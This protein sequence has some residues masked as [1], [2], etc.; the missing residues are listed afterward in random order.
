[1]GNT[2]N[3]MVRD[4]RKNPITT[5]ELTHCRWYAIANDTIGGWDVATANIPDSRRN[6]SNGEYEVG[7]F[8]TQSVAQHIADIHNKWWDTVVWD[9]YYD[10][11]EVAL[12]HDYLDAMDLTEDDWFDY[13][14]DYETT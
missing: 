1:M 11:I 5:E 13:D 7:T 4:F 6:Y 9:S 12:Y 8:L 2:D 3:S 10:N 14:A